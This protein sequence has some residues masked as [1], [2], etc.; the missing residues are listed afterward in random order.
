ML[1]NSRS[2]MIVYEFDNQEET[3]KYNPPADIETKWQKN[4]GRQKTL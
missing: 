2:Y 3:M 1:D 4:M